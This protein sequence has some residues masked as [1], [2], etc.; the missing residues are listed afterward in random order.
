MEFTPLIIAHIATATGALLFGGLTLA[1]R[2]GTTMHR[3]FGRFWVMLMAGTALVSFGIQTQGHFSW[4]HLLSAGTLI[5][6]VASIAAV[7]RGHVSAHRRGMTGAYIGLVI[8]GAFTLMP[9]R[10]LGDLLWNA[11]GLV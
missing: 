11:V 1:L 10:R 3:L 4:I 8:A 5:A 6:L 9:G 7:I 2:K